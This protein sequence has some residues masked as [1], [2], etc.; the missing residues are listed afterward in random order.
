MISVNGHQLNV[1]MFPDN[2]SQVW[3]L[4]DEIMRSRRWAIIKWDF[5]HEGELM[6]IC[7]LRDLLAH[8]GINAHLHMSYLP[9][10]RQDKA[11]KNEETFALHTFA[12]LINAMN[13]DRITVLDPHSKAVELITGVVIIEPVELITSALNL[14]NP[15]VICYPDKG[16][17]DRYVSFLRYKRTIHAEKVR[18]QSTGQITILDIVGELEETDSVLIIDDICDGGMTFIKLAEK[19][20]GKCTNVDLYVTHGIFSKGPGCLFDAGISRVFTKDG[21]VT[22]AT[23]YIYV[24]YKKEL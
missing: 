13:F 16:A 20:K 6:H 5:T 3:K 8:N 11:I 15:T 2:T 1:T 12:R 14:S 24:P 18:D 17:R 7:Q 4:P 23:E 10:G 22:R 19:L 21:E 9:Y